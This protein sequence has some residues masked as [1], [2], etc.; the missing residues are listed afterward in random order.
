MWDDRSFSATS[1]DSRSWL[2]F[3]AEQFVDLTNYGR[4]YGY[5]KLDGAISYLP[6]TCTLFTREQLANI[7]ITK[8][9]KRVA[10]TPVQRTQVRKAAPTNQPAFVTSIGSAWVVVEFEELTSK[11]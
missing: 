7:F 6:A 9:A 1:F 3:G 10:P 4:I 5:T 2:G 11:G 8:A